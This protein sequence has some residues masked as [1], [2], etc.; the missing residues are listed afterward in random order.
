MD[1]IRFMLYRSTVHRRENGMRR[2]PVWRDL[3]KK[4]FDALRDYFASINFES[5]L[6]KYEYHIG[7]ILQ[8]CQTIIEHWSKRKSI[9]NKYEALLMKHPFEPKH[10]SK[11]VS[12]NSD[13]ELKKDD[14]PSTTTP[15]DADVTMD[16]VQEDN[17]QLTPE[18][19]TNSQIED[20][21]SLNDSSLQD[22]EEEEEEEV[23][24]EEEEE[25]EEEE[26][27]EM[28]DIRLSQDKNDYLNGISSSEG[29]SEIETGSEYVPT[30][31]TT[32]EVTNSLQPRKKSH[33]GL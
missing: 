21:I 33:C 9:P 17:T 18:S 28:D 27:D 20:E 13:V 25:E 3:Y 10:A 14:T 24:E 32:P 4:I 5:P 1:L 22:K 11:D 12:V 26:D 2:T 31:P 29:A 15:Q 16:D 19:T 23:Q 8:P 6:M 30:P 7:R